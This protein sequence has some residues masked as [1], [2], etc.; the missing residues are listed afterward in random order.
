[1][2]GEVN[3]VEQEL[4]I[5]SEAYPPLAIVHLSGWL[6]MLEVYKLKSL[7]DTLFEDGT[8]YIVLD[9]AEMTHLDSAGIAVIVQLTRSC[10]RVGGHLNLVRPAQGHVQRVLEVTSLDKAIPFFDDVDSALREMNE[11]FGVG[12][13]PRHNGADLA[14][15]VKFVKALSVRMDKLEE[16]LKKMENQ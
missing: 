15:V 5:K 6:A 7:S 12:V 10:S 16:R 2:G 1:V 9:L 14:Q 13:Q 8:K 3:A 11:K 4:N